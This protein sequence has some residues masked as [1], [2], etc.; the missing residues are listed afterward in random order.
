MC[1]IMSLSLRC[2][3]AGCSKRVAVSHRFVGACLIVQSKCESSHTSELVSSPTH[4]NAEDHGIPA[5]NLL[6]A[7]SVLVSGNNFEKVN[8]FTD[9]LGLKT[10]SS[11]TYYLYQRMYVCPGIE[12]FSTRKQ[13]AVLESLHSKTGP[14]I[15]AGMRI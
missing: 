1:M 13:L 12:C 4:R 7:S 10:I 14:L 5:I 9:Q 15:L 2:T 11:S 6:F 3:F 8:Q